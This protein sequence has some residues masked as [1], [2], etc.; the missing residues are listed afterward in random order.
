M[1]SIFT[2]Q[3]LVPDRI[4]WLLELPVGTMLSRSEI[5]KEIF[6]YMK[7]NNLKMNGHNYKCDEKLAYLFGSKIGDEFSMLTLQK[8]LAPHYNGT[9]NGGEFTGKSKQITIVI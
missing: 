4:C 7:T 1:S 3:I 8:L 5:T 2:I 9:F 6:H